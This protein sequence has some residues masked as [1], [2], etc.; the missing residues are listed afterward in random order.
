MKLEKSYKNFIEEAEMF[1]VKPFISLPQIEKEYS[2][3]LDIIFNITGKMDSSRGIIAHNPSYGQGKSFF[4]DVVNHRHL[5]TKGKYAFKRTTARELCEIYTSTKKGQDPQEALNEFIKVRNLFI[6]DIGD[7]LKDGKERSNYS[8][9]LNVLRYVLLQ[10]YDLWIKKGWKTFGTTNLTLEGFAK[11]Y[12]GRVA[13]RIT[14]MTYWKKFVFLKQGSSFRQLRETR[15]LTQEE[16][17]ASWNKFKKPKT[18][19]KV[20]L[21]KYFNELVSETDDYLEN[22]DPSFWS[23]VQKYLSEKGILKESDFDIIDEKML[24]SSELILRRDVRETKNMSLKHAPGQVRKK[25]IDRAMDSI[26]RN[27]VFNMAK[28]IIAKKKFM[29]LRQQKFVFV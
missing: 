1:F 17:Q 23:F 6:D 3:C 18:I 26:K 12:D 4:F 19:E 5:R 27:D 21:E 13:D 28:T 16:I 9:K 15:K 10:R 29:E 2:E 22:K 8:N 20:D 25:E 14:Q 24:D 11:N 7:E